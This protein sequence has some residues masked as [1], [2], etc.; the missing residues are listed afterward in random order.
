MNKEVLD[1]LTATGW[2]DY[3]GA[4]VLIDGQYGS[5]GKGLVAGLLAECFGNQVNY[6]ITNAGPNSGHTS[7]YNGEKIV[8]KQLPTY[9]VICKKVTGNYPETYLSAG[10]VINYDILG[11]EEREHGVRAVISPNAAFVNLYDVLNDAENVREIASTGQ[12]V[13]PALIR[14][15]KRVPNGI[16]GAG[17]KLG[18]EHLRTMVVFMEI[19]QGFSLGINSGF[20]PHVT[21]RECS[22]S[23]ALA[24]ACLPPSFHRKTIMTVRTYPIRVGSTESTSGPCYP[25]QQETTWEAL[26]VPPEL[27]TVTQRIRR[28]FTWSDRQYRDSLCTLDPNVIVLTFCDYLPADR[29]EQFVVEHIWKP[30]TEVMARK[31]DAILLSF[32]PKSED[33]VVWKRRQWK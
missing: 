1:I 2:F 18:L 15:L 29:I 24:D 26:G 12:G 32:G 23:Q 30:Y 10:A 20:Y 4:Y 19:P 16:F 9:S 25:D 22:V 14:K 7:Y 33:V 8:L 17:A 6:V 3:P 31:P 5:T 11:A 21:S 28:V 27:T 13:G